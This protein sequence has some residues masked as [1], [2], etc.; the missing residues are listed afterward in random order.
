MLIRQLRVTAQ[1]IIDKSRHARNSETVKKNT[2][3]PIVPIERIASAIYLIRKQTVMLDADLAKLYQ[4]STSAL[5]QAVTRNIERFPDDFMF[6]LTAEEMEN[7]KSQFV[8]SNPALK[9]ALRKPPRAFTQE[10]VAMLS[11]VLKSQRAVFVNV[12]I[13][14]TFARLR[15]MIASNTELARRIDQHD[16]DISILYDYVKG[17]IG[18]PP[19]PKKPIGYI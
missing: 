1:N 10:G 6:T 2:A 19:V 8:I 13:M 12:A 4:V 3:A 18:P 15:D 14:R 17:L 9:M 5:N 7:W 11:S 16:H